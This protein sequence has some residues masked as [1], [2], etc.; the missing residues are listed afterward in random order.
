MS[1]ATHWKSREEVDSMKHIQNLK[2][3]LKAKSRTSS[4]TPTRRST[5]RVRSST[6]TLKVRT[7]RVEKL[8]IRD[9]TCLGLV[10]RVHI[11]CSSSRSGASEYSSEIQQLRRERESLT[12]DCRSLDTV[13]T[14]MCK[15]C[16]FFLKRKLQTFFGLG[17]LLDAERQKSNTLRAGVLR[18]GVVFF[19]IFPTVRKEERV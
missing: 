14:K 18:F 13:N 11:L 9:M 2:K 8:K 15:W 7:L 16:Q 4:R 5:P 19:R 17:E 3:T 1:P 10:L 12:P 6:M